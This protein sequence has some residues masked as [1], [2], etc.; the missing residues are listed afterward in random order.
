M[1]RV[2]PYR[3]FRFVVEFDH[4][5]RGGFAKVKGVASDSRFESY[6][7]GGQ[8][9]F[10]HKLFTMA[11]WSALTLE[12]GLADQSLWDWRAAVIEGRVQR[13]T[14][15]VILKDE[16]GAEV[17]RWHAENAFPTKWSVT[18]FDAM[19]GQVTVE[20]VEFAHHGLRAG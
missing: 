2:D 14:I 12:R 5:E 8:N 16:A 19:N 6:H 9:E 20:A 7:E 11:T 10:E 18:D 13:K 3:G 17:K 15:S 1:A 4:A